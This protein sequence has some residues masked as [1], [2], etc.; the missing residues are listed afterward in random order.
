M[1]V[2]AFQPPGDRLLRSALRPARGEKKTREKKKRTE[3]HHGIEPPGSQPDVLLFCHGQDALPD[4][5]VRERSEPEPRAAALQSRDD[6]GRIVR[7]QAEPRVARVLLDDAPQGELRVLGHRVALVEDHELEF[8][9]EDRARR[10][11]VDDLLPDDADPA[12]VR[13]VE[14]EDHRGHG[15]G[16]VERAGDSQDGGSLSRSR[17]TVEEE[18]REAVLGDKAADWSSC[19]GFFFPEEV[20]VEVSRGFEPTCAID[21]LFRSD[22]INL[23]L[24][25]SFPLLFQRYLHSLVSMISPCDATSSSVLG[26]YFST[27]G[28]DAAVAAARARASADEALAV[29]GALPL[30]SAFAAAAA[31]ASAAAAAASAVDAGASTMSASVIL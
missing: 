15:R 3:R 8:I 19:M 29:T 30:A 20:E 2:Q 21:R 25:F 17:G 23:R 13:G 11:E 5:G 26:L 10:G 16:P 22:A 9:G 14:L 27:Q 18:V 6:L 28:A 1:G 24:F 4:V 31:E 7:D 12:V